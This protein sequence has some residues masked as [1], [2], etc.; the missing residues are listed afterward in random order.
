M[1]HNDPKLLNQAFVLFSFKMKKEKK[2]IYSVHKLQTAT[3]C[4]LVRV[5]T[6]VSVRLMEP[7]LVAGRVS[8]ARYSP[9]TRSQAK[10][11]FLLSTEVSSDT[12]IK[13][14]IIN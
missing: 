11:A 10:S 4:A 6:L 3:P 7:A 8:D 2:N 9:G 14:E 5:F 12:T 1:A 13:W